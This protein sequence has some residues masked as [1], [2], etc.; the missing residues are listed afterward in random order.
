MQMLM[1]TMGPSLPRLRPA[2]TDSMMPTDLISS[3][4]L[5]RKPRMMKPLRI[6][7][8]CRQDRQAVESAR[9][10]DA[11]L[12][13]I[14][15]VNKFQRVLGRGKRSTAQKRDSTKSFLKIQQNNKTLHNTQLIL[16]PP[17]L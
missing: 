11:L 14:N 16:T 13:T 7:L 15:S 12:F 2:A 17:T 3:V 1:W 10:N 9:I 8:I 6:V 5:P 4:H